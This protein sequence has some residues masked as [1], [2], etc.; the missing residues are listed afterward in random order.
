MT[1]SHAPFA[2]P[3]HGRVA[4][5]VAPAAARS[6]AVRRLTDPTTLHPKAAPAGIPFSPGDLPHAL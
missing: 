6:A 5:R 4:E 3:T 2:R 1:Q